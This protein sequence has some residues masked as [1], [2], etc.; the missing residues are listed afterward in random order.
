MK[1][2]LFLFILSLVIGCSSPILEKENE[3]IKIDSS[4]TTISTNLTISTIDFN[5]FISKNKIEK[6]GNYYFYE[7]DISF[8]KEDI[9][10]IIKMSK[11]KYN[12]QNI[13]KTGLNKSNF[14]EGTNFTQLPFVYGILKWDNTLKSNLT[15]NFLD[16]MGINTLSDSEVRRAFEEATKVWMSVAN[17]T[18][19]QSS[20]P[21][22]K[23][24]KTYEP[25]SKAS[26]WASFPYYE[27][28]VVLNIAY[29][30]NLSFNE[31]RSVF[32]HELGHTLGL[33]HEHQRQE[34]PNKFD[35]GTY[36]IPY[37]DYDP[38][39]IMHYDYAFSNR[40]SFGD[41]LGVSYLYGNPE[42]K[43]L[44]G[45]F[46]NDKK[47]DFI[48]ISN[49]DYVYTAISNNTNGYNYTHFTPWS[50]YYV[51]GGNWFVLD[52][53]MDG[54]DDLV[55]CTTNDYIHTW[56][57]NG[58]GTFSI[59]TFKPWSGYDVGSGKWLLADINN[60]NKKDIIHL[61]AGYI[62]PWISNG[63]GTFSIGYFKPWDGYDM[64]TGN[65]LV[66]DLNNDKKED[67][68]HITI[69][70]YINTWISN[71][72]GTFIVRSFK[73]WDGYGFQW[74]TWEVADLNGDGR[75]ELVHLTKADYIHTWFYNDN[76]TFT[77]K[78]YS[79]WAGYNI[80]WGRWIVADINGDKKDDLIHLTERDYI[81]PWLSNGDGNFNV[82]GFSPWTGYS[83]NTGFWAKNS[84]LSGDNLV[85]FVWKGYGNN[86]TSLK[87]G[88]FQVQGF[89]LNYWR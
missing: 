39:S 87:D 35:Q 49:R 23:V 22:I 89:P 48:E 32:I 54:K 83:I 58:N 60:D 9:E 34:S 78:G 27:Q 43:T 46:N 13:N 56:I 11:L 68:I 69:Y 28:K 75:K 10:N 33:A 88:T 45:D 64:N 52:L 53:N 67:L 14:A 4:T 73:P 37:G 40:L 36:G 86:W 59:G 63:N 82:K 20:N 17:V 65:W 85:H 80:Q 24:F 3:N 38:Y 50:G 55:H 77:I 72:N 19:Y 21:L 18:F 76:G 6:C 16:N 71:G 8:T 79:P 81:Q 70:G 47:T 26:A 41:M 15:Y 61:G 31:M 1:K 84:S 25:S 12:E 66:A 62:H 51:K 42:F 30:N 2:F 57:S 5:N 29:S 44:T 7:K 74:G